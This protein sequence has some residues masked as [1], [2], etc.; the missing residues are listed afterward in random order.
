MLTR[1]GPSKPFRAGCT[2]GWKSAVRAGNLHSNH[3]PRSL[4]APLDLRSPK[5]L[6]PK[7]PGP[8]TLPGREINIPGRRSARPA[9]QNTRLPTVPDP[10]GCGA[11]KPRLVPNCTTNTPGP[12][13]NARFRSP[14]FEISVRRSVC[15]RWSDVR[16][17]RMASG[18]IATGPTEHEVCFAL[19][20]Y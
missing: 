8:R 6:C 11:G 12:D 10:P 2:P 17:L 15:L 14:A 7:D 5:P 4:F 1:P 18:G 13:V 16:P 3:Q 9:C 20:Y 19:G